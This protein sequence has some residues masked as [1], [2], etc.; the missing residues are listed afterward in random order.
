M[1]LMG[2]I[3]L[4]ALSF[5]SS[6]VV[7]PV[8]ARQ[9]G[10]TGWPA[11]AL[12]MSVG[13]AMGT[14]CELGWGMTG[15]ARV[16]RMRGAG[17]RARLCSVAMATQ[18][19]VAIPASMTAVLVTAA[20]T[21]GHVLASCATAFAFTWSGA[22]PA[23]FFV[24]MG[25]PRNILFTDTL[26]RLGA[27][28]LAAVTM[29]FGAPLVTYPLLLIGSIAVGVIVTAKLTGA[30][31]HHLK[32]W[33]PARLRSIYAIQGHALQSNLASAVYISLPVA[34][35]TAISPAAM[36]IFA[37]SERM[38]RMLLNVVQALPQS[39]Q[40]WV[41][42]A[43]DHDARK[44]RATRAIIWNAAAGIVIGAA[45]AAFGPWASRI[46]FSERFAIDHVISSLAGMVVALSMTSRATG[47]LGLVVA[48]RVDAVRTSAVIGGLVGVTGIL[49]FTHVWGARG[50][51]AAEAL[52]EASVLTY[53]YAAL[54]RIRQEEANRR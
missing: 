51:V 41:H 44:A 8:I 17:A 25:Q 26:P 47:R 9:F 42:G 15:P 2:F 49:L 35:V 16:A 3:L 20:L 43:T 7:L 46:L 37:T 22:G 24:G 19:I 10:S 4:P 11:V 32:G 27:S 48:R 53:Q 14:L 30:R 21:P 29:S 12:G 50:A 28:L 5:L 13:A 18:W 40:P 31:P 6:L 39:L 36:P 45:F 38:L 33:T 54:M 52:A 1:R 23:W 34:L